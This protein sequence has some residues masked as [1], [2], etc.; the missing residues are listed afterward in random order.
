MTKQ[1]AIRAE[2]GL[3]YPMDPTPMLQRLS[4]TI[5]QP[6]RMSNRAEE[7]QRRNEPE[8]SDHVILSFH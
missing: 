5:S 1:A 3:R 6:N 2:P 7:R 4:A 8:T